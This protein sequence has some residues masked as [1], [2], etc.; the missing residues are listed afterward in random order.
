MISEEVRC[1][2]YDTHT[3]TTSVLRNNSFVLILKDCK[4]QVFHYIISLIIPRVKLSVRLNCGEGL[5]EVA[6]CTSV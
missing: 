6:Y 4:I 1:A 5:Y 3:F 2:Y